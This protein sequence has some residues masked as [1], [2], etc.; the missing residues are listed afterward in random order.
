M[1]TFAKEVTLSKV[2]T[3]LLKRGLLQKE[4][5]LCAAKQ[6]GSHNPTPGGLFSWLF[7]GGGPGVS[8]TLCCF[9]V[10]STW[11]FVLSLALCYFVLV[12]FNPFSIV[13]TSLGEE[14]ANLS[15]F[16]MFV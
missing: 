15:A 1:V 13:I 8:L 12:F 16:R 6:I 2:L 9:V 10:Y 4:R 14:S 7:Y 5:N 11:R 3:S